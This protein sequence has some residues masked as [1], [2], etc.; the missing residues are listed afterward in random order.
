M[1]STVILSCIFCE[2]HKRESFSSLCVGK[3][4]VRVYW[5]LSASSCQ[6]WWLHWWIMVTCCNSSPWIHHNMSINIVRRILQ[7][8]YLSIWDMLISMAWLSQISVN[9]PEVC[10]PVDEASFLY[11]DLASQRERE[12]EQGSF[13]WPAAGSLGPHHHLILLDWTG[14]STQWISTIPAGLPLCVSHLYYILLLLHTQLILM[15]LL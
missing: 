4:T 13:I 15:G 8:S 12:R 7:D 5:A 14:L 3:H 9:P 6:D 10:L 11:V 2:D 1:S